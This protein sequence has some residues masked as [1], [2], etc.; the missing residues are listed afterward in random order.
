MMRLQFNP[1]WL[2]PV[3]AVSPQ[4]HVAQIPSDTVVRMVVGGND[5]IAPPRLTFA[6]A[7]ALKHKGGNVSIAVLKG[8]GHE[9]FLESA[10]FAQLQ[11]L[12][13]AK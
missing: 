7:A 2:W 8:E 11:Q 5:P 6:Y 3:D 1:L 4:D 13:R 10:V 12:M 9:V